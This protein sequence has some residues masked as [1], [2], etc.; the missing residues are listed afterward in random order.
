MKQGDMVTA[1]KSA[2]V[3]FGWPSGS[4]RIGRNIKSKICS[5]IILIIIKFLMN[6]ARNSKE[7]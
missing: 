4:E 6:V 2:I 5:K 7:N 1:Y 3:R